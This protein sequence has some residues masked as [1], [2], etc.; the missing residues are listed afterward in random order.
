MRLCVIGNPI[1][2][3]VSPNIHAGFLNSLGIKN[4]SYEAICLEKNEL[5]GFIGKMRNGE[6]DGANVTL[7]YK[8]DII[9]LLDEI[10]ENARLI[11]SVNT[12]A[13]KGELICG[14]NTDRNGFG[15]QLDYDDI[16]IFDKTI[17][18]LGSGGVSRSVLCE[19][20]DRGPRKVNI[21][22]RSLSNAKNL[23]N[24]FSGNVDIF[25]LDDFT[26]EGADII[27]NTTSVGM[28]PD[29]KACPV[30]NL[31]GITPETI[32]IDLIYSPEKTK[33]LE[34]A[35]NF[36]CKVYNGAKMLI[37]QAIASELIWQDKEIDDIDEIAK[38][39]AKEVGLKW[40]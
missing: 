32:V 24:N 34:L 9:E 3:S 20:L 28:A 8:I 39:I 15:R 35:E 19:I 5:H 17:A 10:S 1:E 33:L 22:N 27:I 21:Y 16:D 31:D 38:K 12:I 30:S 2:H 36:N 40:E 29:V 18:I 26:A 7:P 23:A 13:K 11:G 14:Y 6:Y 37:Y 25:L 4:F